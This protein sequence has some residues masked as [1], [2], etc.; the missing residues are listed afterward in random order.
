LEIFNNAIGSMLGISNYIKINKSIGIL[1]EYR[2]YPSLVGLIKSTENLI[3]EFNV[4]L[5][6]DGSQNI[7]GRPDYYVVEKNRLPKKGIIMAVYE[8]SRSRIV[9][10]FTDRFLSGVC[11]LN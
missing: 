5:S 11:F 4:P 9:F 6:I 1:R 8:L 3:T 2:E 7:F 10:I